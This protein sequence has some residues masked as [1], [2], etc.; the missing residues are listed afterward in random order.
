ML[1]KH[2]SLFDHGKS[3]LLMLWWR[4]GKSRR[5]RLCL[6]VLQEVWP[7][8]RWFPLSSVV[9]LTQ[10]QEP[11]G[12]SLALSSDFSA[13]HGLNQGIFWNRSKSKD[14][15][16]TVISTDRIRESSFESAGV[17]RWKWWLNLFPFLFY[18]YFS[19]SHPLPMWLTFHSILSLCPLPPVSFL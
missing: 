3:N 6:T 8:C 12:W 7:M 5:G 13:G 2:K 19:F 4:R 10:R 14:F 15:M 11:E 1:D 17:W 18:S 9:W 16:I